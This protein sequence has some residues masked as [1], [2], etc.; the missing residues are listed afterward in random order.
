MVLPA[1]QGG[2]SYSFSESVPEDSANGSDFHSYHSSDS[3]LEYSDS[4]LVPVHPH[5]QRS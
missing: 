2:S 3:H 1:F 5:F 4:G